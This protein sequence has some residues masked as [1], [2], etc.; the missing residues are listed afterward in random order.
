MSL[1]AL[2][3]QLGDLPRGADR[4]TRGPRRDP[5]LAAAFSP[6]AASA[7][8]RARSPTPRSSYRQALTWNLTRS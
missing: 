2:R 6:S 7:S 4:F 8:D 3:W 1:G 5:A